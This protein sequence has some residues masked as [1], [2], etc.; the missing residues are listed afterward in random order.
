MVEKPVSTIAVTRN[1][2]MKREQILDAAQRHFSHY[3]FSKVTMNEIA[4]ELGMG[5]ASLYYYFPTKEELFQAVLTSKHEDFLREIQ[6]VQGTTLPA[7]KKIRMY[8]GMRMDYFRDVLNLNL[9]DFQHW[10][11]IRPHLKTTFTKFAQREYRVI[12]EMVSEG[13]QRGEFEGRSVDKNAR[14]LLQIM[15]GVRCQFIRSVEGPL[16]PIGELKTLKREMLFIGDIFLK[17]IKAGGAGK[18]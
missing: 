6:T 9:V 2:H 3:G 16:V 17:G 15:R 1:G 4:A 8:I 5:K 13:V 14:A 12:R 18:K 10:Q 11:S 7:A